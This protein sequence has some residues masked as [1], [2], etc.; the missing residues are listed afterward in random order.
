M[1]GLISQLGEDAMSSSSAEGQHRSLLMQQEQIYGFKEVVDRALQTASNVMSR[2]TT[3]LFLASKGNGMPR[4]LKEDFDK[5]SA[6]GG[7]EMPDSQNLW[8]QTRYH[9]DRA[10]WTCW[11]MV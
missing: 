6:T 1:V 11:Y 2:I 9:R 10:A 7:D 4:E 8:H 5:F 3:S